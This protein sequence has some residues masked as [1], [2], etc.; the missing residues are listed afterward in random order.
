M[1][2]IFLSFDSYE[3]WGMDKVS[4]DKFWTKKNDRK[5]PFWQENDP[6]KSFYQ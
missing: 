6:K 2:Q 5:S 3:N 4:L 1:A